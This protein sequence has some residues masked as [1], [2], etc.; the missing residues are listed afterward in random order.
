VPDIRVIRLKYATLTF[1][2]WGCVT[3]FEDGTECPATPHPNMPHYHVVAHRLGYADDLLGYTR[4]HE[5]AHSFLA[6]RLHDAPSEVL[7]AVAHGKQLSGRAAAYEELASQAFQR[8]L[9]ANERPL[10]S[11]VKWDDLKRDALALLEPAE[12]ALT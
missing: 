8:W 11:G 10:I 9:R 6:E 4:E 12:F 1:T 3:R 5:F 7:W 2:E